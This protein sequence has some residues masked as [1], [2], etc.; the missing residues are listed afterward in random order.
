MHDVPLPEPGS[1]APPLQR[2]ARNLIRAPE[3]VRETDCIQSHMAQLLELERAQRRDRRATKLETKVERENL[4]ALREAALEAAAGRRRKMKQMMD[5]NQ[6]RERENRSRVLVEH[7]DRNATD[8]YWPFER[9]RSHV[10]PNA[11]EYNAGRG[12]QIAQ[13]QNKA[14]SPG[15]GILA[16]R[17]AALEPPGRESNLEVKAVSDARREIVLRQAE[18]RL[19]AAAEADVGGSQ[20]VMMENAQRAM[21]Q[22]FLREKRGK[23]EMRAALQ[24]QQIDK[25]ARDV[26]EHRETY[27]SS[28][29]YATMQA[30]HDARSVARENNALKNN[31]EQYLREQICTNQRERRHLKEEW[32]T[33][34]L[35]LGARLEAEAKMRDELETRKKAEVR[36]SLNLAWKAQ[37]AELRQFRQLAKAPFTAKS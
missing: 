4:R 13:Q 14:D 28:A 24:R 29:V 23:E 15:G 20:D 10:I 7:V 6:E 8:T 37:V 21:L 5:E 1:P 19:Q 31:A 36:A 18:L 22:R 11:A 3:I 16:A 27:G 35:R 32:D 34:Q 2:P 25:R 33:S 12:A 9:Q 26:A 17:I 30:T